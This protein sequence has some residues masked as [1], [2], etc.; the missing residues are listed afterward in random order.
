V[1]CPA[2]KGI[3]E[4]KSLAKHLLGR[5]CK[6]CQGVT[7]TLSDYLCFLSR[8]EPVEEQL[9]QNVE[10]SVLK[11]DTKKAMVCSCGQV[12]SKFRISH[13]SDRRVDYCSGCQSIWLDQGE[14]EHLKESDLHRCINKIFTD[15]YQRNLR[16]QGTKVVLNKN[17]E[18]QLGVKDYER[19][20]DVRDWISNDSNKDLLMAYLN[21]KDPYSVE[22]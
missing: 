8:S 15:P 12:M 19:L 4:K 22:K 21:A 10:N 7:F 11:D 18:E 2:C 13:D 5:S 3:Y 14:W 1:S 9:E 20:K 16:L 6:S 17:Y